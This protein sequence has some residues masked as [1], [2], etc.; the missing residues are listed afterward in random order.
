MG[1][2]VGDVNND[3]R[4]DVYFTSYGPD[5]LF[6][7][8][9]NG[10]FIDITQAS[11]IENLHWGSSACFVDYDRDGWL[12]LFVSNYL[13]YVDRVCTRVG[14]GQRDYCGPQLFSGTA[15]KLFRNVT[16]E[17]T[18]G[19]AQEALAASELRPEHV[20][21]RDVS[22]ESGIA[23]HKGPGLGVAA[24]DF[25]GDG[26]PDLY[27]ANDQ[28]ANFLWI[29]QHNGTFVEE[30]IVR[31]C[32][33]D[34]QGNGQAS[35]GLALGDPDGDL[36]FDLF[37]THLDGERSTLYLNQMNG[38]FVDATITAGLGSA[39]LPFTGFGTAFVDLDLDGDEDLVI[40]NGRVK[41]PDVMADSGPKP[42]PNARPP[43]RSM[44]PRPADFWSP[45]RQHGQILLNDG[46][47]RFREMVARGDDLLSSAVLSRGLAAGDID[48]DGDV[49]LIINRVGARAAVLMNEG[50]RNGNWIRVRVVDPQLGRRDVYGATV[51]VVA[52]GRQWIRCVQPGTSY[53]SSNDP[54]V[55]FGIGSVDRMERIEVTWPDGTQSEFSVTE[56]N[57]EHVLER[58]S[59]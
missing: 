19:S 54:R 49:D 46:A 36:D 51:T 9:G 28:T 32:A 38:Q 7:N 37:S 47:C 10:R 59:Q 42:P 56:V 40:G 26:W 24:A 30:A 55:H 22:L 34:A 29:N 27:V 15:A 31:G 12:D 18:A 57:R 35:M 5:Q 14:G 1:V 6:L 13:D 53:Q 16:G 50:P 43:D 23:T 2:A 48:N 33:Y 39:T 11:G 3:G 21:F 25:N 44:Q 8:Q 4:P 45:Y 58:P 17:T 20:R 52:T 41:R